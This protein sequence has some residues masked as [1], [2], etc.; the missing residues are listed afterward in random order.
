[1]DGVRAGGSDG[2]PS[3]GEVKQCCARLYESDFAKLLLGDSFH[4]GGARLT[5][6]LGELLHLAP[7]VRVLDVASGPGTSALVLAERF[8]ADVLG[9]DLSARHVDVANAEAS[10]RGLSHLVRFAVGDAE[11][12]PV[13]DASFDVVV[14][15]CAFCTFPDKAAAAREF[16]RVLKPGGR[17]GLSDI[18]REVGPAAEFDDLMAWIACLADAMPADA[19]AAWLCEGGFSSTAVE[20]HDEALMDMVKSVGTRLLAAEV[21]ASLNN[22]DIADIDLPAAKRLCRQAMDAVSH[23]R[24][25]YA[26][27]MAQR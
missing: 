21:I 23:R 24:L 6:R 7:G 16:S 9:V 8:G 18:T 11:R 14:C 10:R 25:G 1:M 26:I 27:V 20:C 15:E 12:L 19:Y 3:A 17:L 13:D 4:P 22:V 2:M 5:T